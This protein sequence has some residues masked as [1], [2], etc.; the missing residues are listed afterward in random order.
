M[1]L[2]VKYE[3]TRVDELARQLAELLNQGLVAAIPTDTSYGLAADAKNESAVRRV[4]DIKR[5]PYDQ[6]VSVF[7]ARVDDVYRYAVVDELVERFLVL[8]PGRVTLLVRAREKFPEPMVVKD[9][10]LGIRVSPHPL[11]RK[12]AQF[13]G[14]P[15]TAT[16]ANIHG[17]PPAY[18]SKELSQ[19]AVDVIVDAGELPRIA[20]STVIDLTVR[21]PR[22]VRRG[23]VTAEEIRRLTGVEVT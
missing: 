19:L 6:P 18:S 21:P 8:L 10:K 11:P 15:I 7:L 12:I 14:R 23:P 4:F 13:L 22:V 16:S 5:R 2:V 20:V 1:A 3:E 9:G 17:E